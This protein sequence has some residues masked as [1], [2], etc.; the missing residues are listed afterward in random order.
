MDYM[1]YGVNANTCWLA[2]EEAMRFGRA[3]Q[4]LLEDIVHTDPRF[5]PVYLCKVDISDGF[6]R[7]WLQPDDILKLG[8]SFPVERDGEHLVAFPPCITD[9]LGQFPTILLCTHRNRCQ[10]YQRAHHA[11]GVSAPAPVG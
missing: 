6:F 1:F 10:C 9:G 11:W 5:G 4:W 7:V 2:L 8:I 3:F